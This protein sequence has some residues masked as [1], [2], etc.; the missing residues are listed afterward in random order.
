MLP[1]TSAPSRPAPG[2]AH[3]PRDPYFT[4]E[5]A[6]GHASGEEGTSSCGNKLVQTVRVRAGVPSRSPGLGQRHTQENNSEVLGW[7]HWA[8]MGIRVSKEGHE[9]AT[10]R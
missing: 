3:R 9:W 10:G 6:K 2:G 8:R 4:H 7:G 5:G 1:H